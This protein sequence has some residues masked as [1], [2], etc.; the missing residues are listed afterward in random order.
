MDSEQEQEEQERQETDFRIT[1]AGR[2]Q[3]WVEDRADV[4][5]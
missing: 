5:A 4:Q 3:V 1:G 2:E